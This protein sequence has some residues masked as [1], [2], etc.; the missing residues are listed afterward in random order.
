M[1][2][3]KKISNIHF[4]VSIPNELSI[5]GD[6]F[7]IAREQKKKNDFFCCLIIWAYVS[8]NNRFKS[9]HNQL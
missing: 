3:Y 1:F 9:N 2:N 5:S 7:N 6:K 4:N 8:N